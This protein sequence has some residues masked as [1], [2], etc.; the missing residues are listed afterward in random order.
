[1]EKNNEIIKKFNKWIKILEIVL[2]IGILTNLIV[3]L[4]VDTYMSPQ[5]FI[6]HAEQ[7]KLFENRVSLSQICDKVQYT[8]IILFYI[9][10]I[11]L[12]YK[13]IKSDLTIRMRRICFLFARIIMIL[14]VLVGIFYII[15]PK[16]ISV[17]YYSLWPVF[18]FLAID[19]VVVA[20]NNY[21]KQ[22]RK[23]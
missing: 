17:F 10:C 21:I 8:C 4:I 16:T 11:M 23:A 14:M 6:T 3:T 1:M 15:N 18:I 13:F 19:F 20:L 9:G 22:R 2:I 5:G 7:I 12:T